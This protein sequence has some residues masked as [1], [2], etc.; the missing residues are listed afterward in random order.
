M[1]LCGKELP[2]LLLLQYG[3]E[4]DGLPIGSIFNIPLQR[5]HRR[6]LA[7]V[8]PLILPSQSKNSQK[9][10]FVDFTLDTRPSNPT[11]THRH[12]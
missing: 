11:R 5:P 8:R 9:K 1:D 2:L 12:E 10:D 7:Q 6:R 3:D 4:K